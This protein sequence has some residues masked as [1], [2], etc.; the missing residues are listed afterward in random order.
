MQLP[1]IMRILMC[2][3]MAFI[4]PLSLV[5]F[6]Y[7][8]R[9][10]AL[11]SFDLSDQFVSS[12]VLCTSCINEFSDSS[13]TLE[14][15]EEGLRAIADQEEWKQVEK[16]DHRHLQ[17]ERQD[18]NCSGHTTMALNS[19]PSALQIEPAKTPVITWNL[20]ASTMQ[21]EPAES[22]VMARN[23]TALKRLVGP[24]NPE[25][26]KDL[27]FKHENMTAHTIHRTRAAEN[28]IRKLRE[29]ALPH[30]NYQSDQPLVIQ[31]KDKPLYVRN[32]TSQGTIPPELPSC[33][34]RYIYLYNLQ[35]K[36]NA[37]L[38]AQCD[39]LERWLNICVY[40]QHEGM[41]PVLNYT[42]EGKEAVLI[43]EGSWHMTYQHSLEPIFHVRMKSYDCLTTDESKASLFYIPYYGAM[44][45]N[46]WEFNENA[47]N[48]DRDA[49]PLD[50][51]HW[52][53][54]QESWKRNNGVDHVLLLGDL[55]WDFRRAETGDWGSRLFELP[56][57]Y[58]PTKLL[59]ERDPWHPNE[60]YHIPRL[61]TRIRMMTS[62]RGSHTARNRK[63]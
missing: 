2:K 55:S 33:D 8:W 59:I 7:L 30:S 26:M 54:G 61:S 14:K 12:N 31:A 40:L 42:E 18:E 6:L 23:S 16:S 47:T 56:Q 44:D 60:V 4:P 10:T 51:V 1:G 24:A 25:L 29:T 19:T 41:G 22:P 53:E 28:L 13:S 38:I 37:D 57:M 3:R 52:L 63:G 21:S 39:T 62:G 17:S 50:L 5:I 20:T 11:L 35:S 36:F 27:M 9:S 46:R 58:A 48:E 15:Q 32:G 49:L 34:G 43:P 45:V